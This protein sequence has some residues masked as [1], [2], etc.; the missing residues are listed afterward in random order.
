MKIG[1]LGDVV[2]RPAREI[3][4][5]YLP[6]ARQEL[7]LDLVVANTENAS[8]GFG[9]NQAAA[10]ELMQSG[11]DIMT[12]GNHSFDNKTCPFDS[13]P[14]IRPMNYPSFLDGDYKITKKINNHDFCMIN[15]M[16]HF[17]MPIGDNIF[18]KIE[19]IL[20]E[21][22]KSGIKHIGIDFHAEATSEKTALFA[23]L[24]EKASF[25]VGTHTHV[26]TDDLMIS[27][28]CGYVSD[29]GLN[30]CIDGV[31]GMQA[32]E[33]IWGFKTGLKKRFLVPKDCFKIFQLTVFELDSNANCINAFKYKGL[34]GKELTQTNKAF[35][36]D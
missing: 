30:G 25:I 22:L 26:G 33:P 6:K 1:F 9:I 28:K 35:F 3:I 14:I 16:G 31:I 11:V 29:A 15:L 23:M 34:N 36:L 19:Q 10:Q 17:S 4:A 12:G 20:D 5:H 32:N 18:L 27:K 24:K 13:F 2:G 7:G 8:G 21:I